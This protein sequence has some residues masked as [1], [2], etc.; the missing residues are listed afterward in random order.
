MSNPL[1]N[2]SYQSMVLYDRYKKCI[3]CKYEDLIYKLQTLKTKAPAE[4]NNITTI[5]EMI[6]RK[7]NL[8]HVVLIKFHYR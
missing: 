8:K 4:W 6:L 7:A 1:S 2:L 5:F 3:L